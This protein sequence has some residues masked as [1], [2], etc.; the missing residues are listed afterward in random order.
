MGRMRPTPRLSRRFCVVT[1]AT[2]AV[3][4]PACGGESGEGSGEA[5]NY[6]KALAG[7]PKPLAK[8]YDRANR[9]L[10]GGTDAFERQLTGLRGYPVVVNKWA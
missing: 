8:L 4:L 3:A 6:E 2:L 5:P 1:L 7:A 9:L 10:P